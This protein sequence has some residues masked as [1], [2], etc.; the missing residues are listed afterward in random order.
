MALQVIKKSNMYRNG[1]PVFCP[2][3]SALMYDTP[4]E[5][6]VLRVLKDKYGKGRLEPDESGGYWYITGDESYFVRR[7]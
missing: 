3:F 6:S 1:K 4:D 2:N 5:E 7:F